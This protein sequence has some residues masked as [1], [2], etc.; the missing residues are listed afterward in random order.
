MPKSSKKSA[1]KAEVAPAVVAPVKSGK[2]GKRDA[3]EIIEK[4]VVS[5]KKQKVVNGAVVQAIEKTKT[6]TKT[7]K[8]AK[9]QQSSS[10]EGSSSS[11]SEEEQKKV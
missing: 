11:E 1:V 6:E 9:K 2:K 8:S 3:E 7:K 5:S 10:D 4:Q